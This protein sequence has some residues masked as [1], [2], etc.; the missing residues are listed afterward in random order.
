[1]SFDVAA[2][3]LGTQPRCTEW[4]AEEDQNADAENN[5]GMTFAVVICGFVDQSIRPSSVSESSS[6]RT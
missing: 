4:I 2:E 5:A 1:M 3:V 6:N